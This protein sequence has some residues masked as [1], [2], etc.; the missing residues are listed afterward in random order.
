M[1][2]FVYPKKTG[3][4]PTD[5]TRDH[6]WEPVN[7]TGFAGVRQ[8]AIDTTWSALGFREERFIERKG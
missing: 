7:Q 4:I 5:I 2:W 8:V 1:L 6:G 3:S